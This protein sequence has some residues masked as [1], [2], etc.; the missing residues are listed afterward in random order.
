MDFETQHEGGMKTNFQALEAKE[1]EQML[2][3]YDM[4]FFCE[5][6]KKG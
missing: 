4:S 5:R 1:E 2:G 6:K 3:G